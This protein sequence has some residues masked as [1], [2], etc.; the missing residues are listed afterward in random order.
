MI[1]GPEP[2]HVYDDVEEIRTGSGQQWRCRIG[3]R[4][5]RGTGRYRRPAPR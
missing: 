4:D 3:W 5:V 2:V 1:E